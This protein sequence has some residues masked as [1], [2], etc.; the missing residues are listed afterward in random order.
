MTFLVI[1]ACDIV[2][3]DRM[4]IFNQLLS[5]VII[6]RSANQSTKTFKPHNIE[7]IA[8]SVRS[9]MKFVICL[10]HPTLSYTRSLLCASAKN[11]ISNNEAKK[12]SIH[13][14]NI[15]TQKCQS[16]IR[17]CEKTTENLH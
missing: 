10:V 14:K 11:I 12:N 3:F 17:M 7:D 9:D 16:E 15:K 5:K 13:N 4:L 1:D 6:F 8:C 2:I